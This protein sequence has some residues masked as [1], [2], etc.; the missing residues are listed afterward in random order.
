MTVAQRSA[1]RESA[2]QAAAELQD[3]VMQLS[4][5]VEDR[6][7]SLLAVT[8]LFVFGF[9]ASTL[10]WVVSLI[11][12]SSTCS[13]L[14]LSIVSSSLPSLLPPPTRTSAPLLL[15]AFGHASL[16]FHPPPNC[17]HLFFRD[18]GGWRSSTVKG[19]EALGEL[20]GKCSALQRQVEAASVEKEGLRSV[21]DHDASDMRC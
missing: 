7:A 10:S 16:V 14:F 11:L 17:L 18:V 4:A 20:E 5:E 13:R 15:F 9:F 21:D 1:E 2:L 19:R 6:F 3:R 12:V 8:P